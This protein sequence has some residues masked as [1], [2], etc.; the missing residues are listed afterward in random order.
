MKSAYDHSSVPQYFLWYSY[1]P[2]N[3][4][5]ITSY[6]PSKTNQNHPRPIIPISESLPYFIILFHSPYFI[7]LSPSLSHVL[8]TA[9]N[10]KLGSIA[11]TALTIPY[12]FPKFYGFSSYPFHVGPNLISHPPSPSPVSG[13]NSHRSP[14]KSQRSSSPPS[15]RRTSE[16]PFEVP[17]RSRFASGP[18]NARGDQETINK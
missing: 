7:C 6:F 13:T 17:E 11:L 10:P 8:M 1:I 12:T 18:V 9:S 15:S 2:Y 5:M 4:P 14:L 3:V 16:P